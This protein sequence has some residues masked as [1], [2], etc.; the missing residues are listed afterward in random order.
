MIVEFR[1]S[2]RSGLLRLGASHPANYFG[3][4]S[5]LFPNG[6]IT[7]VISTV[8]VARAQTEC[9]FNHKTAYPGGLHIGTVRNY[10]QDTGLL[11]NGSGARFRF[12]VRLGCEFRC[13]LG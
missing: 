10:L 5:A 3:P 11:R 9:D 6:T 13:E 7:L 1:G 4:L 2:I 12:P 8:R